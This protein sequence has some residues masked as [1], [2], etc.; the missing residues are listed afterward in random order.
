MATWRADCWLGQS[1]GW[2]E[3]EVKSN[4][5]HGAMGQFETIYGAEQISN[6]R[7]VSSGR[8]SS[9]DSMSGWFMIAV[10][11]LLTWLFIQFW[12]I[13]VPVLAICI[14]LIIYGSTND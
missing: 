10:I 14:A 6:L 1:D 7:E 11:M 2:Q 5:P 3:L 8:S 4:T 13:V 12:W 9:D